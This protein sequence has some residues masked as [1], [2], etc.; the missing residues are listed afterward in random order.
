MNDKKYLKY[1]VRTDMAVDVTGLNGDKIKKEEYNKNDIFVNKI[2]VLEDDVIKKGDYI[3]IEFKDYITEDNKMSL[4]NIVTDELSKLIDDLKL[5]KDSK[6]LVVGLGNRNIT[7][8][9]LGSKVCDN[10]IV[11]S[12]LKDLQQNEKDFSLVSMFTPGVT[13]VTGI[14]TY[15]LVNA[16]VKEEN[17][18]L[19]IFIDALMSNSINRVNKSIQISNTGIF[20]GS[21]IGNK[22]KELSKNTLGVDVITIGVPTVTQ[23]S[24]IVLDTLKYL[25]KSYAYNKSISNK[26][27]NRLITKPV[28]YLKKE[29]KVEK[30][31]RE[32]LLGMVG[33]LSDDELLS[34]IYEILKPIGY[35]LIVTPKEIDD[36]INKLS[37]IISDSINKCL[38][39]I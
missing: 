24:T 3:T 30:K 11:T 16:V 37:N 33:M 26:K 36:D 4:I 38:H 20:P 7:P 35:N 32:K 28:N 5:N 19:V 29:V 6:I 2:T 25:T 31:D 39:N 21:G 34:L 27:V 10:I 23:A 15:N 12:H 9:A 14:E 17:P 13:G 22:R 1:Q 8:D 18:N